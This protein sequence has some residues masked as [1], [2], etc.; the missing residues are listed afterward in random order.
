VKQEGVPAGLEGSSV[1]A[2]AAAP[3]APADAAAGP[4]VS[5]V[6]APVSGH[7]WQNTCQGLAEKVKDA[8]KDVPLPPGG[9]YKIAN[10]L[11][12]GALTGTRLR[13]LPVSCFMCAVLLRDVPV[14][15][16]AQLTCVML[17]LL[18]LSAAGEADET[19]HCTMLASCWLR[20]S[21]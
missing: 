5:A 16:G 8:L 2:A 1:A 15:A 7:V 19:D 20:D 17:R 18:V 11:K 21:G 10:L 6:A 4:G 13:V 3:G 9:S 12:S 14:P